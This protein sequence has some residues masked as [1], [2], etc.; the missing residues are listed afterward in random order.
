MGLAKVVVGKT[1]TT[2]GTPDYFAPELIQSAG[3]SRA[4][5]WWTLGILTFE[6]LSGKPPFE[7]PAPM[8]IYQKVMRGI[9][10]VKFPTPARGAESFIKELLKAEPSER[11]PMKKGGIVNLQKQA[12]Y[13]DFDWEAMRTLTMK[14]PYVPKVKNNKDIANF[15]CSKEDM[16]PQMPYKDPGTGW[17]KDFATSK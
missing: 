8:Q 14:P 6:L 11:L 3:H 16:P 4:L 10:K 2:C 17:D 7:S 15:S 5:D 9:G 1:F 12:W 13:K